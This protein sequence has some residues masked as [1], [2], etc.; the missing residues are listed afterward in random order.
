MMTTD[1]SYF[2]DAKK[3]I[4]ERWLR[5]SDKAVQQGP[6]SNPF[7]FIPFGYGKRSRVGR[8]LA[9]MKMHILTLR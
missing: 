9:E 3:F 5:D 1:E 8:R 6:S 2:K 4:P 7:N